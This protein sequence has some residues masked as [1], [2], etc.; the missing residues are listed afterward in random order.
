MRLSS[1]PAPINRVDGAGNGIT[2][3]LP[4]ELE[5]HSP[6]ETNLPKTTFLVES[7][8][9]ADRA[10]VT[11]PVQN[12]FKGTQSPLAM[13]PPTQRAPSNP[14]NPVRAAT[15][16]IAPSDLSNALRQA[17][18]FEMAG[19]LSAVDQLANAFKKEGKYKIAEELH[20][21]ALVGKEKRLG[22]DHIDTL[23]SVD[24]LADILEK[25]GQYKEAGGLRRR[26]LAGMKK[27][28][29]QQHHAT[30]DS[31]KKLN[32]V[33]QKQQQSEI[34][35]P[36]EKVLGLMVR[37]QNMKATAGQTQQPAL[38]ETVPGPEQLDILKNMSGNALKL[39]REGKYEAAEEIYWQLLEQRKKI[40]GPEHPDTIICMYQLAR[41][42][43]IQRKSDDAEKLFRQVLELHE[44]VLGPQHRDT[45]ATMSNLAATLIQ[46]GKKAEAKEMYRQQLERQVRASGFD[47]PDTFSAKYNLGNMLEENEMYEVVLGMSPKGAGDVK[48]EIRQK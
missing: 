7:G 43:R 39:E 28:N 16:A 22:Q 6:A 11:A 35:D 20:R 2:A 24:D 38:H 29:G 46:Q 18:D 5:A 12:N 36:K 34:Y 9:G 40:L 33:V 30:S 27:R 19:D 42:L 14:Q 8:D 37:N 48:V 10:L 31:A 1:P 15:V 21:R 17:E 4:V 47:H 41:V 45:L 44:R 23:V 26:H 32:A 13:W 3:A 25:Q